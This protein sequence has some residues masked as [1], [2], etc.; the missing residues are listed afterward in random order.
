[1]IN[2]LDPQ[3]R[4]MSATFDNIE[5]SV[6]AKSRIESSGFDR[7]TF[8]YKT[9]PYKTGGVEIKASFLSP[10]IDSSIK[11]I[12]SSSLS[13]GWTRGQLRKRLLYVLDKAR[14]EEKRLLKLSALMTFA[15]V[16]FSAEEL[17]EIAAKYTARIGTDVYE[18]MTMEQATDWQKLLNRSLAQ[19]ERHKPTVK[20]I[21]SIIHNSKP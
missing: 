4:P 14:E 16:N 11:H 18:E 9:N 3:I 6:R 1:M 2:L 20:Y 17:E 8:T 15:D 12:I 10:D 19:R 7:K 21:R 5:L 13:P